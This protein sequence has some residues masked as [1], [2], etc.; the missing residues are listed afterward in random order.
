MDS[1]LT[2]TPDLTKSHTFNQ[3]TDILRFAL[4]TG[5]SYAVYKNIHDESVLQLVPP[6]KKRNF[7]SKFY[8]FT[9]DGDS[10][11]LETAKQDLLNYKFNNQTK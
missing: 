7:Y 8:T 1:N 2:Q 9:I 6:K 5:H 10:P 3:L 4:E 11:E